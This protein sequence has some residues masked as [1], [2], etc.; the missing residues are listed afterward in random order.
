[1]TKDLIKLIRCIVLI[2]TVFNPFVFAKISD[3][4]LEDIYDDVIQDIEDE[5]I[6]YEDLDTD[7]LED[8]RRNPLDLNTVDRTDLMK[9]PLLTPPVIINI[10]RERV[11][12]G[13]FRSVED[14]KDVPGMTKE[15]FRAISPFVTVYVA[16]ELER[17][18]G[19]MRITHR[20][21]R[22][23]TDKQREYPVIFHHPEYIFSRLRFF[24]SDNVEVSFTAERDAWSREINWENFKRYYLV[25]N[26]FYGKNFLG[27]NSF[28]MGS[29][30]L[31]FGR[32]LVLGSLSKTISAFSKLKKGVEPYRPSNKN[33][34]FYGIALQKSRPSYT[35]A[36]WF[37]DKWKTAKLNP[38]GS[39]KS[40]YTSVS[41][42]GSSSE[43]FNNLN[44]LLERNYGFYFFTTLGNYNFHI[45]GY[46]E[47]FSRD[48]IPVE[49]ED[50]SDWTE[51]DWV[52]WD[53]ED[54]KYIKYKFSGNRQN[55]I[56]F[57]IDTTFGNGTFFL[58]WAS[59][60]HDKYTSNIDT[61]KESEKGSAFQIASLYNFSYTSF[62]FGFHRFD[63][64]Y[65]NWHV[66]GD[67]PYEKFFMEVKTQTKKLKLRISGEFYKEVN[68]IKEINTKRFYKTYFQT[69]YPISEKLKALFQY[70]IQNEDEKMKW[71]D[72]SYY[73]QI[74]ERWNKMRF[75][76]TWAPSSDLRIRWKYEVSESIYYHID[77]YT[78]FNY[79]Q[80]ST[81]ET[82]L[83]YRF[84][85][86]FQVIT[87][88]K[89]DKDP[90][91][92]KTK[93]TSISIQ[94]KMKFSKNS[95]IY[96][97]FEEKFY[98]YPVE[99]Y[100]VNYGELDFADDAYEYDAEDVLR[101]ARHTFEVKYIY[102]F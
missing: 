96:M 36:L 28:I 54:I 38:D 81:A 33:A 25:N 26:Y 35:Y 43:N 20:L 102:K 62:L 82:E 92:S 40:N 74:Y 69:E 97:K 71:W 41:F 88:I 8:F 21:S 3:S 46:K 53:E 42:T 84:S 49:P 2:F 32:G 39:A 10:I 27:F 64:D 68:P 90:G 73:T 23:F 65:Y 83:K 44:N 76:L 101:D 95:R 16:E 56:G 75:R 85:K 99:F 70:Q 11:R 22:P 55:C 24:Y 57:G 98:H 50:T 30:K 13:G 63:S 34:G 5:K 31:N 9:L 1:M 4:D 89:I 67:N 19:E 78:P 6:G 79:W 14:L 12:R 72:T 100:D 15:M 52:E 93:Y 61:T 66:S 94:P 60:F 87:K 86:A 80:Y 7:E 17:L 77:E 37:S 59:S 58:D 18:R 51:E 47:R 91:V 29:F 45:E 48:I